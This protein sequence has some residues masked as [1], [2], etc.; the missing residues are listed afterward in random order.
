[1]GRSGC[2]REQTNS[3]GR[4]LEGTGDE[5]A[6]EVVGPGSRSRSGGRSRGRG[7]GGGICT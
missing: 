7:G 3:V 1:M 5:G 4:L 6:W 2:I